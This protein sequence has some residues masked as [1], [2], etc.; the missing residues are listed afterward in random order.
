MRIGMKVIP[1]HY[2]HN[3]GH[4]IVSLALNNFLLTAIAISGACVALKICIQ[5]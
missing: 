2:V 3:E 5:S 1:E 4:K